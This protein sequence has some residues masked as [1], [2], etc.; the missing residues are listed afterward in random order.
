MVLLNVVPLSMVAVLVVG[1]L[2]VVGIFSFI[3]SFGE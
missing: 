2:A 3:A 1:D